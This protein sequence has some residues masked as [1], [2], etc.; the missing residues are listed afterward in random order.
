VIVKASRKISK[1]WKKLND[2]EIV[3]LSHRFW[4]MSGRTEA[5]PRELEIAVAWALPLAVL[6]MPHLSVSNLRNWLRTQR[7][8]VQCPVRDRPLRAFLIAK[9]GR[10]L[11][12]LDGGDPENERRFSLAHEIAHFLLDYL[13]PR[14]NVLSVLGQAGLEII[15]GI[16]PATLEE[17][18]GGLF[19]GITIGAYSHLMDRSSSGWATRNAVIESEDSAD[20][21]A[22]ELLAPH[23]KVVSR[24]R[25][26]GV[27]WDKPS[28]V[29]TVQSVLNTEFGL[30]ETVSAHFGRK[31][32]M[33]FRPA[34][35]FKEWL[36][37]K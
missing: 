6:K 15:D 9:V 18:L 22:I 1:W 5:F 8:S 13:L 21:L 3:A 20:R 12:I 33:T 30:P 14:E 36:R 4:R 31:L 2:Q 7:I 17:R 35:S 25:E 27:D 26:V 16:R 11:V 23:Q 24:L 34:C 10:G 28:A 32:V 29:H 37:S 19:R